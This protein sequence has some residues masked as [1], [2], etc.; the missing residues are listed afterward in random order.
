MLLLSPL[1]WMPPLLLT[2]PKPVTFHPESLDLHAEDIEG[3][4][5]ADKDVLLTVALV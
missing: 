5:L 3:E 1:L 2:R 4:R